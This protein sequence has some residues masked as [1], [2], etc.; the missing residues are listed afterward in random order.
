M[1]SD[2]LFN[3]LF[4]YGTLMGA[5]HHRMHEVL[6]EEAEFLG[7]ATCQGRLYRVTWY[8]ALVPSSNPEDR[9]HGEAY[10]LRH[11]EKT[12]PVID[13]YEGIGPQHED[14]TEYVRCL[15]PI[16]IHG[17]DPVEAWTYLYQHP[18]DKLTLLPSGRF[19]KL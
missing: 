1:G 2:P 3:V 4:V 15:R 9:V 19:E 18:T 6:V 11:P 10:R 16:Q 14:P 5:V 17:S 8:P 7:P 13:D 12:L